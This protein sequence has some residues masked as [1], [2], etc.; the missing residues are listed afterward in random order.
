[1][2]THTF[3]VVTLFFT[4]CCSCTYYPR[5]TGIPLIKEKGDTRIE[6]GI[7]V[8]VPSVQASISC[9]VT[10]KIAIQVAGT[11]IADDSRHN[12]YLHGAIGSY[13][14]IN[15]RNIMELYGGFAYGYGNYSGVAT[16][17]YQ[18]GNYQL[19]FTQF[20][21][22]NI[23]KNTANMELGAGL[24]LG[25][26]HTNMNVRREFYSGPEHQKGIIVEPTGFIR[27][28]GPKWKFHMALGLGAFFQISDNSRIHQWPV[29][30]GLG[31]S[32]SFGGVSKKM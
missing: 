26:M 19:Y 10:D 29:N 14:R 17:Q 32:Y 9:G 1:M 11:G 25:Y 28:G 5:L 7:T 23:G 8:P 24:K 18:D 31:V 22:G 12:Y 3:V 16:G 21:F 4:I 6:G 13:K 2:K 30:L 27:H 15:D 20:N